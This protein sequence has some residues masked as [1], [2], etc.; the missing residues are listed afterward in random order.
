VRC[1][2]HDG[3]DRQRHCD[4]SQVEALVEAGAATSGRLP[5]QPHKRP[6]TKRINFPSSIEGTDSMSTIK[7]KDGATIL[8]KD[9]GRE[10]PIVFHHGLPLSTDDW[11]TQMLFSLHQGY[12]SVSGDGL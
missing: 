4:R 8:Y 11:D 7:T 12:Q 6:R 5:L 10:Q 2:G 3:E 1:R 9:W